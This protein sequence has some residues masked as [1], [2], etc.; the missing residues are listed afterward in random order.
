MSRATIH[1]LRHG[2]V[3]NP[4]RLLYGRLPEFHL[5]GLGEQ[6]AE[7]AAKE[8]KKRTEAGAVISYLVSSPLTRAQETAV[9]TARALGLDVVTDERIIEATN[10][11][12]GLAVTGAELCHA[13]H[14]K[15][16]VNPVKPSWGEPYT[17]QVDRVMQA[18]AEARDKAVAAG[19]AG[20]EAV[21]VSHQLPIWVTR[22]AAEKRRLWHDP[23]RRKCSL[24]SITSLTFE[25]DEIVDVQYSEPAADLLS[26]AANVPGA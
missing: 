26:G 5:S 24:A 23:R 18:V 11:F 17:E 22:R 2:E 15:H 8:F 19:G 9:P 12:E 10:R 13:K 16:L 14:W 6:M 4:D 7:R 20:A 3:H 21:M 1:M 25:G